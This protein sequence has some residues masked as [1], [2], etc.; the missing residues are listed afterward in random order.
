MSTSNPYNET[1][2][3]PKN[4]VVEDFKAFDRRVMFMM[5]IVRVCHGSIVNFSVAFVLIFPLS[6]I[7]ILESFI[8]SETHNVEVMVNPFPSALMSPSKEQQ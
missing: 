8:L 3:W 7:G 2:V 6:A 1:V 4:F 5:E